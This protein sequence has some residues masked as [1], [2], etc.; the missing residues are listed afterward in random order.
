MRNTITDPELMASVNPPGG[1]PDD[2]QQTE[3][4]SLL[5]LR[6]VRRPTEEI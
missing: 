6:E 2:E 4:N 1:E 3:Q 5:G